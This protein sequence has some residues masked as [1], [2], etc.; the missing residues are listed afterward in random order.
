LDWEKEKE[1]YQ[2]E[3]CKILTRINALRFGT[4]TLTGGKLSPYYVDLR[5]IPSFPGAFAR[6]QDM[7]QELAKQDVTVSEFKRVAGIPTAG[8]P[9]ASVLAFSLHKPF[10]YIRKGI[11]SYGRERRVEGILHPGDTVLLVDDLITSGKNLL[12]AAK[13]L[14]SEGGIIKDALVLIDR[15]EGGKEALARDGI[16]L[17]CLINM[18]DVARTLFRMEIITNE[19]MMDILAQVQESK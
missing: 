10:V 11:K 8:I 19:Q 1:K 16:H 18:T 9:F 5:I 14:R 4:F 17:H 13:A 7:Y 12:S 2:A 3:L 15:E 6:I